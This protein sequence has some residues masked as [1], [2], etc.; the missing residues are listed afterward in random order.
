M[1]EIYLISLMF[2]FFLLIIFYLLVTYFRNRKN[3][4]YTWKSTFKQIK[5]RPVIFVTINLFL[6]I[7]TTFSLGG[8][9][10]M[11]KFD[12]NL[13]N[14]Q[15]QNNARHLVID[16]GDS[17]DFF[18]PRDSTCLSS[19]INCFVPLPDNSFPGQSPT[20]DAS[21]FYDYE[22]VAYVDQYL[23]SLYNQTNNKV[24]GKFHY[25]FE[26][27]LNLTYSTSLQ[28]LD[29]SEIDAA[30]EEDIETIQLV[31]VPDISNQNTIFYNSQVYLID[32]PYL[33][34]LDLQVND[35]LI[36]QGE[37]YINYAYYQANQSLLGEELDLYYV[38]ET[39][40]SETLKKLSV[41]PQ[42]SS[43]VEH[44]DYSYSSTQ[45]TII[46]QAN[47]PENDP[48]TDPVI[49]LN[50]ADFDK[51]YT[52][53]LDFK[54][55]ASNNTTINY[56]VNM[57][58]KIVYDDLFVEILNDN[59]TY[60]ELEKEL[61]ERSNLFR[62]EI[63]KYFAKGYL[64]DGS[65]YFTITNNN[66]LAI[67]NLFDQRYSPNNN[68]LLMYEKYNTYYSL[69]RLISI[70]LL[71]LSVIIIIILIYRKTLKEI[72]MYGTLQAIGWN[73]NLIK[74][75]NSFYLI[76]CLSF[77]IILAGFLSPAI[78]IIWQELFAQ[79]IYL[80][81]GLSSNLILTITSIFL[82]LFLII[83][84]ISYILSTIALR[85]G[86]VEK[87]KNK[88]NNKPNFLVKASNSILAIKKSSFIFNYSLKNV[89]RAT[90]R[91]LF[92]FSIIIS[93]SVLL[94]FALSATKIVET[95]TEKT[96][97]TVNLDQISWN[98]GA[99]NTQVIS[100]SEYLENNPQPYY[101]YD[102]DLEL[103]KIY[104]GNPNLEE[105]LNFFVQNIDNANT[106]NPAGS[107]YQNISTYQYIDKV[108]IDSYINQLNNLLDIQADESVSTVSQK[109]EEIENN[110]SS[111]LEPNG[112]D[113]LFAELSSLLYA[114]K[115]TNSK[116]EK[117]Y[118]WD[119]SEMLG[120][121][122][123]IQT[124][125]Q[126]NS[127]AT[128][129]NFLDSMYTD[130][131]EPYSRSRYP[132]FLI[133]PAQNYSQFIKM[134]DEQLQMNPLDYIA[135][136]P[137][138]Q[139]DIKYI[140][141]DGSVRT[142]AG[143][144]TYNPCANIVVDAVTAAQYSI[145]KGDILT[146]ALPDSAVNPNSNNN[147]VTVH[148]VSIGVTSIPFGF[149]FNENSLA[150]SQY[151]SEN[152][153][154]N[155]YYNLIGGEPNFNNFAATLG[156][157]SLIDPNNQSLAT[158]LQTQT[159][160]YNSISL[161]IQNVI[162]PLVSSNFDSLNNATYILIA[163]VVTV[164]SLLIF[165]IIL[166]LINSIKDEAVILKSY[167]YNP[168]KI[169]FI[170]LSG[171]LLFFLFSYIISLPLT[172]G[173]FAAINLSLGIV[174]VGAVNFIISPVHFLIVLG[175]IFALAIVIILVAQ[176]YFSTINPAKALKLTG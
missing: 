107:L 31:R 49:F 174:N 71:A 36:P 113:S 163:V 67:F 159:S 149:I 96:L 112:E 58:F 4:N 9:L 171:Y 48:V 95:S 16:L 139:E 26:V 148:V 110:Y 3:L 175:I 166:E 56:E 97:S 147:Y 47:L 13:N 8:T 6:I 176:I 86:P 52:D 111:I 35:N 15:K 99:D 17:D 57:A 79:T 18:G 33:P 105:F 98:I 93:M 161:S 50:E 116:N 23:S 119:N 144:A 157:N 130:Q 41:A 73:K 59:I 169:S 51:I 114:A 165:I 68:L 94:F 100:N 92:I 140:Y 109:Y 27:K 74:V 10:A 82:L 14:L 5:F 167:G 124:F 126:E 37:A 81:Y 43:V 102:K 1:N 69:N 55:N 91:S 88:K 135:Q 89:F 115:Q 62:E 172:L 44:Y 30:I 108:Q 63:A 121:S 85:G 137:N 138:Y 170:T 45:N 29:N 160:L 106:T 145:N 21:E 104:T 80:S 83:F 162:T 12:Y 146:I 7:A 28:N 132:L 61:I 75:G 64:F 76:S 127:I 120:I 87:L 42:I 101:L 70:T 25:K 122:F 53:L 54:T 24:G 141:P 65:S 152:N 117:L 103:D 129:F 131:G 22:G 60:K 133:A 142:C 150:I 19:N 154:I 66:N 20:I 158:I 164:A 77:S 168:L 128:V 118:A 78:S 90:S 153:P 84:V 155:N 134:Y 123:N 143:S 173:L 40:N 39:R 46:S 125:N 2:L 151:Y 34:N 136:N 156:L 72:K 11:Q 38:E 32:A